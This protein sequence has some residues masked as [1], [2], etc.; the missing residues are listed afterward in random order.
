MTPKHPL[1]D[2]E[3]HALA[4]NAINDLVS[5]LD[6]ESRIVLVNDAW[7]ACTGMS[8]SLVLG[9][10]VHD[11]PDFNNITARQAAVDDCLRENRST[12]VCG[13]YRMLTGHIREIE[14]YCYPYRNRAG[15]VVGVVRVSHDITEQTLA[16]AAMER[17]GQQ[18]QL[19]NLAKSRLLSNVSHE[20]RTPLNAVLGFTQLLQLES[21]GFNAQQRE[22]LSCVQ[23][24]GQQLKMLIDDL[25]D[26][27][28]I[29]G[30]RLK[31]ALQD[32]EVGAA[33]SQV[34]KGVQSLA[35]KHRVHLF[36]RPHGEDRQ[37]LYAQ[38]DP[39]RLV[40]VLT[41]LVSNAIKYNRLGGTVIVEA[42][43]ADD[44][45]VMVEVADT[46]L[47]IPPQALERIFEPF[48]RL[49]H[50]GSHIEGVG[51]GL[52]ICR[53]LMRLM[54]GEVGVSSVVGQGSRFWICLRGAGEGAAEKPEALAD[55]LPLLPE[56][57]AEFRGL[58]L[59]Y[60]E[61]QP[62]NQLLMTHAIKGMGGIHLVQAETAEEGW[63]QLQQAQFDAVLLDLQLPG[64]SG[65]ALLQKIRSDAALRTQCVVAV[66]ALSDDAPELFGFDL[67]LAKPWTLHRLREVLAYVGRHREN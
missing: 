47:G 50:S 17:A 11:L 29:E 34:L 27:A 32:V 46:G 66:T 58:R 43:V 9:Q 62:L 18:A 67:V 44:G 16:R 3:A 56:D 65:P 4:L 28:Q 6:L 55:P 42:S 5:V 48:E 12:Y 19:A 13:P 36:Q 40:Q 35:L 24:S 59:L 15:D 21:S 38:A 33:I 8:R 20:L 25:L 26:H 51:L 57:R 1:A 60:I 52:G 45:R 22:H 2:L 61:D 14:T 10:R 23:D 31:V 54:Q 37:P 39:G 41:N 7:I 64:M 53:E 63:L 49:E 30:H